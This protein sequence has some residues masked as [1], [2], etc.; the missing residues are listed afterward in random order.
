MTD[1][2]DTGELAIAYYGDLELGHGPA[3]VPH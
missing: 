1:S 2:D 3:S